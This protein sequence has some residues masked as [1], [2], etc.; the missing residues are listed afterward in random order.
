M[1]Y[2]AL[3]NKDGSLKHSHEC[4]MAFGKKDAQCP[5]CIELL[6]GAPARDGW[7]KDHYAMQKSLAEV[8]KASTENHLHTCKICKGLEKGV[9]TFGEY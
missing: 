1:T 4:K 3:Y 8:E 5:R 6:N 7:Q 9:C 2:T